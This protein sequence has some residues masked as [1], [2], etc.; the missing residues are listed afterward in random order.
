M[1]RA[2]SRETVTSSR[3]T[4]E[5]GRRPIVVRSRSTAK[6]SPAL[7]PGSVRR[8]CRS[9]LAVLAGRVD[10][11]VGE[12]VGQAL[13]VVAG[14]EHVAALVLLAQAVDELGAQDVDL[15]VQDA[16]LVGDLGLFLG[17]LADDIFQFH[18]RQRAKVGERLVHMS[19]S[20]CGLVP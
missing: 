20:W 16:P 6:L 7:P 15:A 5:S 18:V 11:P 9:S 14:D 12:D 2:W 3:N 10:L 1:S 4:S 19:S 17:E 13:D 8:P